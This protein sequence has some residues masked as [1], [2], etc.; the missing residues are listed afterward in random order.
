VF[1]KAWLATCLMPV[2]PVYLLVWPCTCS[3]IHHACGSFQINPEILCHLL[4]YL[5][6]PNEAVTAAS[7][8]PVFRLFQRS[9]LWSCLLN[10]GGY[11]GK[12]P[13][14]CSYSRICGLIWKPTAF[15]LA[16][17][18]GLIPGPSQRMSTEAW[19]LFLG[20]KVFTYSKLLD[21][22]G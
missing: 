8:P 18:V 4:P 5:S 1:R 2:C 21:I 17:V 13:P 9:V 16:C 6:R 7:W 12:A 3:C 19:A 10:F 14:S 11:V 15:P 20:Q 22:S